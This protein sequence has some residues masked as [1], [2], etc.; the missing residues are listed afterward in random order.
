MQRVPSTA[1][2]HMCI[3]S[4]INISHDSGCCCYCTFVKIDEP[5]H[6]I[7]PKSIINI[8]FTIGIVLSVV[9]DKYNDVSI[10]MMSCRVFSLP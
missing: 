4:I 1:F 8:G 5:T 6:H 9:F 10:I 2:P 7:H 3:T